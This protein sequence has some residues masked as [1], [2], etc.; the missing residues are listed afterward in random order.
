MH[1]ILWDV[2]V[3]QLHPGERGS[4]VSWRVRQG[5]RGGGLDGGRWV[6][7][8]KGKENE[9]HFV[10]CNVQRTQFQVPKQWIVRV[11]LL[12][13]ITHCFDHQRLQRLWWTSPLLFVQPCRRSRAVSA[14]SS[15]CFCF[16]RVHN[17]WYNQRCS[18]GLGHIH[19]VIWGRQRTWR[20]TH[21]KKHI[22]R[23]CR[24]LLCVSLFLTVFPLF[25]MGH[26]EV[27]LLKP[28]YEVAHQL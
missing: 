6:A 22:G 21:A 8:Q 28:G 17:H 9:R 7:V 11:D 15:D 4:E 18:V 24:R 1:L 26:F 19:R 10:Q 23:C 5:C 3:A 25:L 14:Q 20:S 2:C 12:V 13:Q 27:F 16:S